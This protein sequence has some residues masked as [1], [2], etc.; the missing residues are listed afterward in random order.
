MIETTH[1]TIDCPDFFPTV[2]WPGGRGEYDRLFQNMDKLVDMIDHKHFLF[3]FSSFAFG[4]TIPRNDFNSQFDRMRNKDIRDILKEET[5][6]DHSIADNLITLLDVGGNRIFNKIILDDKPPVSVESY[7]LYLEAYR[8]FVSSSN[9]DIFVN[10]D[11]GPSYSARDEISQEGV[12]VWNSLSNREKDSLNKQLLDLSIDIKNNN[13]I[14]VPLS[15]ADIISFKNKLSYVFETY[16]D[17]IDIIGFSGVAKKPSNHVN[18]VLKIFDDFKEENDWDVRTHGLGLG[19]WDNI[20]FLINYDIDT[21]DVGTPWRRACTDAISQPYIPLFDENYNIM[22]ITN[23]FTLH[24][25]YEPIYDKISC[26]CP[27]CKEIPLSE[28]KRRC[29]HADSRYNNHSQHRED[30][31]QMRIRVFFHNMF[32]HKALIKKLHEYKIEYGTGFIIRFCRDIPDGRLKR[33][34]INISRMIN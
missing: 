18:K 14:M 11:I 13:L 4:F 31:Y 26:E 29:Y 22:D 10:F 30:Y 16:G 25:L 23:P 24:E 20:P 6:I 32:Q 7:E 17:D 12:R 19:G 5:S 3:N 28:I 34:L 8:E 2:G 33:K 1:G 21:C 15:G 27:F 9:T